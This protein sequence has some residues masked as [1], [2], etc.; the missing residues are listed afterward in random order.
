MAQ[1]LLPL[2]LIVVTVGG[3]VMLGFQ[4]WIL[5]GILTGLGAVLLFFWWRLYEILRIAEALG[6]QDLESAKQALAKIKNP[7]KRNE[8]SRTYFNFYKGVI[9]AQE[10]KFKEAEASIKKALE[11]GKFRTPDERATAH[12]MMAQFLL[13]K[14]NREGARRQLAEAKSFAAEPQLKE[15]IKVLAKQHRLRMT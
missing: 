3:L 15:Q 12:F 9:E 11:V 6:K 13:R 2:I 7:E 8:W 1:K 10:N 14:R 5:G 4:M